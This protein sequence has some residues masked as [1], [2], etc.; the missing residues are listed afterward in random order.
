LQKLPARLIFSYY[1]ALKLKFILTPADI[2]S[3]MNLTLEENT[4]Q[5]TQGVTTMQTKQLY[6]TSRN[7]GFRF[8]NIQ[9]LFVW[10]TPGIAKVYQRPGYSKVWKIVS[11]EETTYERAHAMLKRTA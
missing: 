11:I 4:K 1:F 7:F 2:T 5:Q 6:V 3:K 8:M 9:Y 10:E